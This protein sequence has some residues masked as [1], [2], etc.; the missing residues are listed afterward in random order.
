MLKNLLVKHNLHLCLKKKKKNF[1][2]SRH[3]GNMLLLLLLL[4]RFSSVCL[5]ATP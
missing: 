5:S 2:E 1:P 4:S 3:R